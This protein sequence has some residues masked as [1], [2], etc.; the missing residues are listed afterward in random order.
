[1]PG[2]T[3]PDPGPSRSGS[4]PPGSPVEAGDRESPDSTAFLADLAMALHRFATYPAGHPSLPEAA[5]RV[6]LRAA[7]LLDDRPVFTLE[8]DAGSLAPDGGSV[9]DRNLM[10][11]DLGDRLR[12]HA[13]GAIVFRAGLGLDEL[14]EALE[15]LAR[16]PVPA[17]RPLG[18][19]PA[20]DRPS[21]PNLQLRPRP[22]DGAAPPPHQGG[23][24]GRFREPATLPALWEALAR[25]LAEGDQV[26][27]RLRAVLRGLQGFRDPAGEEIR[28][29]ASDL[30]DAMG[31]ETVRALVHGG[32]GGSTFPPLAVEA[33]RAGLAPAT[34]VRLLEASL[35]VRGEGLSPTLRDLLF[36]LAGRA[37]GDAPA[38]EARSEARSA[39]GEQV[40]RMLP[41]DETGGG[42][43]WSGVPVQGEREGLTAP[44]PFRVVELALRLDEPGPALEAALHACV[45]QGDVSGILDLVEG[46]PSNSRTASR[47]EAFLFDP[48]RLADLLSG[49]EVNEAS[50]RRIVDVLGD[51]AIAPLFRQLAASASRPV[52]RKI[53]DRLVALGPR[54]TPRAMEYLAS[55]LWYVQRNMLALLQRFPVLPPGFS[56]MHH[57]RSDDV[58]VRREAVPLAFRDP[59]SREEALDAGLRDPDERIV[60]LGLLEL[61]NGVPPS[62]VPLLV[63]RLFG[64]DPHPHL[65]SLVIRALGRSRSPEARQ[66]LLRV[67]GRREGDAGA[68]HHLPSPTPELITALHVLARGWPDDARVAPV[69][70]AA[71]TSADSRV[72]AAVGGSASPADPSARSGNREGRDDGMGGEGA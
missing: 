32:A 39:L 28:S 45:R 1:V 58:R 40:E 18:V 20:G 68:A 72:R 46:S 27:A 63:A 55:D 67:C 43:P 38:G 51:E 22:S 42:L 54:I 53:F 10:M 6:L 21:W 34:V 25:A 65:R 64:P 49:P 11:Q 41:E 47:V 35:E 37:G 59:G 2:T 3:S 57:V 69:L 14:T 17:E 61:R 36:R 29:L 70:E 5:E 50:L 30:L 71:R 31:P 8:V 66:A 52:R 9:P 19:L 62:V 15:T 4:F 60:R 13:V 44:S 56:P 24:R 33:S 16:D 23:E 7:P 12:R 48:A 26:E